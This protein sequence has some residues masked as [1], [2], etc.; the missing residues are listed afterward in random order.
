MKGDPR[1]GRPGKP[2][3]SRPG[4][5]PIDRVL[6][7]RRV[8][9]GHWLFDGFLCRTTPMVYAG[10]GRSRPVRRVVWEHYIGDVPEGMVVK[11]DCAKIE[12]FRPEHLH[13]AMH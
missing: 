6:A 5:E 8:E 2:G 1:H 4:S 11:A 12:C 9:G 13:L 10:H 3:H 7:K